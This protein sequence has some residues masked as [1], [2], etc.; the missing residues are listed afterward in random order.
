MEALPEY[1]AQVQKETGPQGRIRTQKDQLTP[2]LLQSRKLTGNS[3]SN[4]KN[5]GYGI[6]TDGIRGIKKGHTSERMMMMEEGGRESLC[7]KA[8]A[9]AILQHM[10][11]SRGANTPT[12][13]RPQ[14]SWSGFTGEPV[15]L[16][17]SGPLAY[18]HILSRTCLQ[19]Y[20]DSTKQPGTDQ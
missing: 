20:K 16:A 3:T 18:Y 19:P 8:Y 4:R 12:P 11:G 6:P 10:R 5:R 9:N 14:G 7:Q 1:S 17:A 15:R 13:T 2:R